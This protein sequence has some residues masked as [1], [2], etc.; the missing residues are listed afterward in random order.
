MYELTYSEGTKVLAEL[1]GYNWFEYGT[2]WELN[3]TTVVWV[4]EIK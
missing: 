4:E 1:K 2:N 3:T